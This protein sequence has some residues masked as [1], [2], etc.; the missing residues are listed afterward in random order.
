[1]CATLAFEGRG[2]R[3][4]CS[5][6]A[7]YSLLTRIR[8]GE[9]TASCPLPSFLIRSLRQDA[10][11][12][13]KQAS[14]GLPERGGRLRFLAIVVEGE[15]K[16]EPMKNLGKQIVV[17]DNGFVHLGDCSV[18]DGL[19]SID[20]CKN[21]RVWGTK[22]GIGQLATGPTK[23]TVADDCGSVIVPINRVVFFVRVVG[24][25]GK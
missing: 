23:D 15:S 3:V 22:N 4:N 2:L 8:A 17:I 14:N 13:G 16:T 20:D 18:S 10:E 25:W 7:V 5:T 6:R 1:M 21:V 12:I 11:R 24:G 19:L 9:S